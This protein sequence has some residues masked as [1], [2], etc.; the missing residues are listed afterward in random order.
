MQEQEE[1]H[2]Q[3]MNLYEIDPVL[4]FEGLKTLRCYG[5]KLTSLP[6]LPDSLEFLYCNDNCLTELPSLPSNL[7][8]LDCQ[9]NQLTSLPDFPTNL[10]YLNC[11]NNQITRLPVL[12]SLLEKAYCYN[13]RINVLPV[14]MDDN[15][16]TE[17]DCRDNNFVLLPK[18]SYDLSKLNNAKNKKIVIGNLH[19]EVTICYPY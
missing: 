4:L 13:N 9:N 17:L 1:L 16:L 14:L 10:L 2:L 6:P 18:P 12:N 11:Q 19:A 8:Y 15:N 3:N 7:I 5:N